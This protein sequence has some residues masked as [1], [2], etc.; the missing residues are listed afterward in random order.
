MPAAT[1]VNGSNIL[2]ANGG[3]RVGGTLNGQYHLACGLL[4][5][6]KYLPLVLMG[7][8]FTI[9]L[10]LAAGSEIGV[11]DGAAAA[12]AAASANS[13]EITNVKKLAH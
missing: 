13:Y 5:M 7:Q 1:L 11:M 12:A 9:Q 3:A 2:A 8:G 6:G 10:E 4:H